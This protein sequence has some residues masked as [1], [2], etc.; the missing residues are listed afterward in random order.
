MRL[1]RPILGKYVELTIPGKRVSPRGKLI[2][3]G[4]D[5]VVLYNGTQ[6]LY[7]PATHIQS[8][9][10]TDEVEE[11]RMNETEIQFDHTDIAYRKIL[12]NAKGIFTEIYIHGPQSLHG[13]VTSIMNDFFVFFS[14]VYRTVYVAMEHVKSIS[15]YEGNATPFY[16]SKERF[17]LQPSPMALSRTFD[18]QLKRLEGELVILDLGEDPN[19]I[20]RLSAIDNNMLELITA[21]G[22]RV[23]MHI[24]HV[25]TIH[26]P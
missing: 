10:L 5:I 23:F 19:K 13:Y 3:V 8:M 22:Q 15:P 1:L 25:K 17:A 26:L 21:N 16:M 4:N 7:I 6:Y 18:Q 12:M 14:P 20:G 24:R 9:S 2:D 11:A